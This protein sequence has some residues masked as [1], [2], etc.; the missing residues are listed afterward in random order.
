MLL[1]LLKLLLLLVLFVGGYSLTTTYVSLQVSKCRNTCYLVS[2]SPQRTIKYLCCLA[3]GIPC[4]SYQ[5]IIGSSN[6]V[7]TSR[8]RSTFLH[9]VWPG[10]QPVLVW[11]MFICLFLIDSRQD[12][13]ENYNLYLLPVGYSIERNLILTRYSTRLDF[14]GRS[15]PAAPETYLSMSGWLHLQIHMVLNLNWHFCLATNSCQ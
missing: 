6:Q 2:D 3:F 9:I 7:C 15:W 12:K 13:L 10:L 1:L 5:W 14:C 8:P 4:V 11:L